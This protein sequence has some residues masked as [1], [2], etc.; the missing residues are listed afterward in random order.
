[1]TPS[2]FKIGRRTNPT[3]QVKNPKNSKIE[4]LKFISSE[5]LVLLIRRDIHKTWIFFL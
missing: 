1:M 3:L 4:E 2:A 5:R